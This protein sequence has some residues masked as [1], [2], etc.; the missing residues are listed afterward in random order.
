[1][2]QRTFIVTEWEMYKWNRAKL[3]VN[4][5]L[6]AF[7][8]IDRIIDHETWKALSF[9]DSDDDSWKMVTDGMQHYYKNAWNG[10]KLDT[11]I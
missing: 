5:T 4:L 9:R 3:T 10:T 6:T 2:L 7:V 1:M 8:I 11:Y